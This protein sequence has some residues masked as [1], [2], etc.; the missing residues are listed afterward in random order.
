MTMTRARPTALRAIAALLVVVALLGTF[1]FANRTWGTFLVLR[2]AYQVG[3]PA[4]ST[5]RAWMTIGHIAKTYRVPL[6]ALAGRLDLPPLTPPDTPLYDIA[7][8]RGVDRI[9]LV[10]EVQGV[11]ADIGPTPVSDE[12]LGKTTSSG[13]LTDAFLAAI[14]A[15]SYPALALILVLGAIGAPVPTGIATVLAGSLAAGGA[16]TWPLVAAVAITASVSGDIVGYGFGRVAG[17][18]FVARHG[19][20][21]GYAGHRKRR[22]EW[23]FQRWGGATVL[24]TR[25]LVSHLSS[26]ASLLAGL[27]RYGFAAFLGYAAVGRVVWTAAYLGLGYFVGNDLEAASGFLANLTGLIVSLAIAGAAALYVVRSPTPATGAT[28][29]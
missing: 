28:G 4:V 1:A 21:I 18:R 14:L 16:M 2:S 5:V 13:G 10:Q 3:L 26:L 7:D 24:I 20:L 19:Y 22:V 8:E 6:P 9:D 17:D 12:V 23:L 15:Y 29:Q 11:I 25:T 27:S